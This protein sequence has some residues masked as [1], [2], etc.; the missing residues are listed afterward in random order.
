MSDI[1]Q[2]S[3]YTQ[4]TPDELDAFMKERI[5][6]S[7][8]IST[9]AS[10]KQRM[11]TEAELAMRNQAILSMV[12]DGC[13]R[14]VISKELQRRWEVGRSA[15][16]RYI[17]EALDA[18]VEDNEEFIKHA[19]DIAISRLEGVMVDAKEANDRRSFLAALDQYNKIHALY[20][21]KHEVKEDVS[22]SFD[23]GKD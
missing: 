14:P 8:N 22:I 10:N 6:R 19:R 12:A 15:A 2:F 17:R 9:R 21:E 16:N 13:S 3:V 18:L 7:G 4:L 23:F 11:W 1:R 20:T 5:H